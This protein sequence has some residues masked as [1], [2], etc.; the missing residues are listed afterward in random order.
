MPLEKPEPR[1]MDSLSLKHRRLAVAAPVTAWLRHEELHGDS[2]HLS[3]EICRLC[4]DAAKGLQGQ[5]FGIKDVS[6]SLFLPDGKISWKK[7]KSSSLLTNGSFCAIYSA[8]FGS[9]LMIVAEQMM[10]SKGH[11]CLEVGA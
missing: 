7:Y 9:K 1:M 5:P 8:R 2:W 6:S 10:G 3:D 11:P 4:D